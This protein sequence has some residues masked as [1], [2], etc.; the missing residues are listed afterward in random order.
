MK[1][2]ISNGITLGLDE[3]TFHVSIKKADTCWDWCSDYEP[4]IETAQGTVYF[5]DAA[6][7]SHKEWKTG[8]GEG[9]ISHYEGFEAEGKKVDFAFETIVWVEA[10][11]GHVYFE[12]VPLCEDGF[13][14]KAIYWPGKMAFEE[15]KDSWYT[16]LNWEQGIL[17][18][19]H[20]K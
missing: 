14:V 9:F 3:Q 18:P 2:V 5:K 10:V 13:D 17:I 4:H 7:I 15:K 1:T 6:V 16:L 11:T 8:V 12:F 19:I 20:G